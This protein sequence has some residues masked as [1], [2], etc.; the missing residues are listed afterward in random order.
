MGK[1]DKDPKL[2]AFCGL[3]CGS[4][5]KYQKG[6]C[7]DVSTIKKPVGARSEPAA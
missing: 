5:S 6:K 7:P 3:Y 1:I 2:I 4:C